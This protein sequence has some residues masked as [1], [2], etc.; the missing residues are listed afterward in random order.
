MGKQLLVLCFSIFSITCMGQYKY[1]GAYTADGTPLYFVQRDIIPQSTLD[2][3]KQALP[4]NYPVPKYNPQYISSGYETDIRLIDSAAVYITFVGEG[5]GY[6][7]TL[8]F[9]TYPL[10]APRTQAPAPEEVTIIFPNISAQGSGGSL[11]P[12]DKILLGNF[13]ANTGIGFV[14]IADGWRN[15]KVTSGNWILYSNPSFNPESSTSLKQHNVVLYD[16]TL[17]KMILS[18]EDIRRDN[19]GCDNDF[20]DA[21]FYISAN[22]FTAIESTNYTPI[23]TANT[24][25][26]SGNSGGLES[27]GKLASKIALRSFKRD[28]KA[29]ETRTERSKQQLF[30]QATLSIAANGDGSTTT[31]TLSSYFPP[32]GMTGAEVPYVST[33]TDLVNI[34]NANDIFTLDYYLNNKRVA[35]GF[36]SRT[37]QKVYDHSKV[38]CDRLNGSVITDIR[39]IVLNNHKLINTTLLRAN[40]ETEYALHFSVKKETAAYRLYSYWNIDAYP[41]GEYLNFQFWGSNMSEICSI[42]YDVIKSLDAEYPVNSNPAEIQIP[43]VFM[44]SG[45]YKNGKLYLTIANKTK[46]SSLEFKSNITKAENFTTQPISKT[47]LLSG[48]AEEKLEIETGFLFDAG[49]AIATSNQAVEDH[50]YL[51]DGSWGIDYKTTDATGIDFSVQPCNTAAVNNSTRMERD[52]MVKGDIKGVVNLFRNTRA[53]NLPLSITNYN[54]ISFDLQSNKTVELVLVPDSLSDW[55]NRPRYTIT[56]TNGMQ[57]I[58]VS[59]DK[60][61]DKNGQTVKLQNIR[62]IVFSLKGNDVSYDPFVLKVANAMFFNYVTTSIATEATALKVYPN[63]VVNKT[64]VQV[65]KDITKASLQVIDMNGRK[66]VQKEVVFSNGQYHLQTSD[67]FSGIYKMVVISSDKQILST[68]ITVL[69]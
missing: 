28:S 69:K 40:G 67:L 68:N 44:K 24:E 9:Y 64:T 34:T 32:S 51:A 55:D 48:K 37:S 25:I 15:G 5:A 60:F 36:V 54:A 53:G 57:K 62:N 29:I 11:V 45:E 2:K 14:L 4:E 20:N 47:I 52:P 49:I 43:N 13:P 42:A 12:G 56:P 17:Q 33:P 63:P 46:A 6:K 61:K 7:S 35:V 8:G 30:T 10:N 18:F 26:T 1:L 16:S 27:N 31:K 58:I 66:H 39:T 38:I 22:P 65:P 23:E 59:L 21:I 50:F 3:I 19:S 41:S